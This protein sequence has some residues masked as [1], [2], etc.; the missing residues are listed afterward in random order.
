[1]ENYLFSLGSSPGALGFGL[2][3]TA[4]MAHHES[5]AAID[6]GADVHVLSYDEAM[7]LFQEIRASHLK[8]VGVNGVSTT[9]DVQGRLVIT[10]VKA[11]R[12]SN[13]VLIWELR[14]ACVAAR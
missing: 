4:A 2:F 9:A 8:V 5:L 7:K 10:V 13:I 6:S 12:G 1:M 3:G 11:P 14:M